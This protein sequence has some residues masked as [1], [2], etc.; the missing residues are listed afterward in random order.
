MKS[1]RQD[2]A[3]RW[4]G[5]AKALSPILK[6]NCDYESKKEIQHVNYVEAGAALTSHFG[7]QSAVKLGQALEREL[8]VTKGKI[9][10]EW[11]GQDRRGQDRRGQQRRVQERRGQD[12]R[13]AGRWP[14]L[15]PT[16]TG[17]LARL[18]VAAASSRSVKSCGSSTIRIAST[19]EFLALRQSPA[20]CCSA[21]ACP[22]H[23]AA[24]CGTPANATSQSQ[25]PPWS[26]GPTRAR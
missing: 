10:Q 1:A 24:L 20:G 21:P 14:R 6:I 19:K 3:G 4:P 13:Q 7:T 15:L 23:G 8:E 5:Q 22:M 17:F 11:L 18:A 25:P 26:G 9:G 16:T 12:R 2:C